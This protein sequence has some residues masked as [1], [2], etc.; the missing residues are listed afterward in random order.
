MKNK[1][2]IIVIIL[3]VAFSFAQVDITPDQLK[4]VE[5][6]KIISSE[7][8]SYFGNSIS[9]STDGTVLAIGEYGYGTAP[10]V[11]SG[12]VQV[13]TNETGSW[14]QK[15]Q[16][17]LGVDD[18]FNT[19]GK[20]VELSSDGNTI[21]VYDSQIGIQL[22]AGQTL[23]D[24][25]GSLAVEYFPYIQVYQFN[26]NTWSQIGNDF[27]FNEIDDYSDMSLSGDG[28]SLAIATKSGTNVYQWDS[29]SWTTTGQE[30][31]SGDVLYDDKIS[32]SEDGNT[33]LVGDP[34]YSDPNSVDEFSYEGRVKAYQNISNSWTQ[35][36]S[37]INGTD[38]LGYFGSKVSISAD[39]NT[40]AIGT[41]QTNGIDY[42]AI[43][44]FVGGNW[45]SKG[46]NI[47]QIGNTS[48]ISMELSDD[49]NA[50]V[51]GE[52]FPYSARVLKYDTDWE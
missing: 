1:L 5:I 15:G 48:I 39:G 30:I 20:E 17:I 51:V 21:A 10:T 6:E 14:I 38:Y 41:A 19:F 25:Y 44:E 2:S 31:V 11:S 26:N 46:T 43:L 16:D 18:S 32:L 50:I 22:N 8:T 27:L 36:G 28:L 4:P 34:F 45:V 52:S 9:F 33:L 7:T 12:R 47:Q 49:G 35:I 3:S 13:Y 23:E 42:I 37:T 40:M 29:N 24:L